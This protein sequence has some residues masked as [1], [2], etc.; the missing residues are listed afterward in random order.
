MPRHNRRASAEKV[1]ISFSDV[2][3]HAHQEL[4]AK[5]VLVKDTTY[6]PATQQEISE[7]FARVQQAE[8]DADWIDV[9]KEISI[10]ERKQM[11]VTDPFSIITTFLLAW[12]LL[13][14]GEPIPYSFDMPI[15]QRL[16]TVKSLS[17]DGYREVED[18]VSHHFDVL[19]AERAARKNVRSGEPNSSPS[20]PSL[21]V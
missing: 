20:S 10:G 19:Q 5:G 14:E 8:S 7:S 4:I 1:R 13:D 6:R 15:E 17:V 2:Y 21:A 18:A 11:D 3:R 9:K 16:E 12:S